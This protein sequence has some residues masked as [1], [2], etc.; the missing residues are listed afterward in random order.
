VNQE[1]NKTNIE[2]TKP[3]IIVRFFAI[4]ALVFV[5]QIP[6]CVIVL[7][8]DGGQINYFEHE[9]LIELAKLTFVFPLKLVIN[10]IHSEGQRLMVYILNVAL[11][12]LLILTAFIGWGQLRKRNKK[13]D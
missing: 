7:A 10:K 9:T 11:V 4:F 2:D 8:D 13:S 5:S 3:S 6:G 1:S 12:S